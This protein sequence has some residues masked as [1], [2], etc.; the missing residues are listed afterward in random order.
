MWWMML[1]ACNPCSERD[2]LGTADVL[3]LGDSVLGWNE[4]T[5]RSIPAYTSSARGIDYA[6]AAVNGARVLGGDHEIREQSEPGAWSTVVMNGG[7]NDLNAGCEC[8]DTCGP[9]L[10]RLV[11][12]DG[13]T[14]ALPAL[15]DQWSETG[16]DVWMLGYYPVKDSAWYGFDACFDTITELD[17]RV[18]RAAEQRPGVHFFDLGDVIGTEDKGVYAFDNA[19]PS[20]EGASR[21]GLAL[22]DQL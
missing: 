21:L 8:S 18:A 3:Y 7:A 4:S 16:A 11:S 19:H 14:G 10:D 12:E 9:L 17:A 22:A 5:C 1:L 20:P 13:T 6:S 2:G 15:A